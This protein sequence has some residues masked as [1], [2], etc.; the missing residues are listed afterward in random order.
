LKAH[1]D[2]RKYIARELHDES[3]QDLVAIANRM[4]SL[5]DK[6][7]KTLS[8][9]VNEQI[10]L[11]RDTVF[12]VSEDLRRLSAN[13]RPSVLDDLGL[14]EALRSLVDK[15]SAS[16]AR[17]TLV[18]EGESRK[19]PADVDVVVFRFI[20]E[21]LSNIK[22]HSGAT[23][24]VVKLGFG[25]E[26]VN[27]QVQDNGKGIVLPEPLSKLTEMNK[28]GIIGMQERARILDGNFEINSALGGG[29]SISLG[30]RA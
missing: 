24:A 13:L 11:S 2:E 16:S 17:A 14:I 12:R 10:E 7:G 30:F 29:T 20:Q 26:T 8:R 15:F 22:R 23:E 6:N 1:E 25:S 19:L 5:I 27:I 21:A 4:Q 18:V 3:I 28:F 9:D